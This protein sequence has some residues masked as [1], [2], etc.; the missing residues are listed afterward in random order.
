[1]DAIEK[2]ARRLLDLH[3]EPTVAAVEGG[4]TWLV[5]REQDALSAI[6]AALMLG[7]SVDLLDQDS[8]GGVDPEER[9]VIPMPAL[10]ANEAGSV[11]INQV[12]GGLPRD[13]EL[14]QV[15]SEHVVGVRPEGDGEA[16]AD[17]SARYLRG[18]AAESGVMVVQVRR[19]V[20]EAYSKDRIARSLRIAARPEV[21]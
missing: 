2:R 20:A 10:G 4:G 9:K 8:A 7:G 6:I 15:A 3:A 14:A 12:A 17:H 21:L 11:G 16:T 13:I 18:P 5:V 1:M 19:D